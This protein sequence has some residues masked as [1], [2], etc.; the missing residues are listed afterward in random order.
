MRSLDFDGEACL[1]LTETIH[2][3]NALPW[4][5]Y[6]AGVVKLLIEKGFSL[7]GADILFAST[8]PPGSGLSSSACLEIL[9][10]F[11]MIADK[12]KTDN[13]R[14]SMAQICQKAENEFIG[15]KCGIMDQFSI[16][17]GKKDH[18]ILLNTDSLEFRH[19]PFRLKDHSLIIM[20]SNKP[21]KLAESKYNERLEECA[22][23]VS[24]ISLKKKI[25]KLAEAEIEDIEL[26][27]DPLIRRRA[28]HVITE[29]RRVIKSVDILNNDDI[30]KF[31]SMMTDSHLSLKNDYEVSGFELD[32][33]VEPVSADA[34]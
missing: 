31:G 9:T 33:L 25:T 15:V 28:R 8:L 16:A 19:V 18:A 12:V 21:R 4:S 34:Q 29:N 30:V 23:A 14:I 26:I 32:A 13:E 1:D 22:Q 27:S 5:N 11:I 6:P 20:N 7:R 2:Y 3:N 24:S 17:L 10:A